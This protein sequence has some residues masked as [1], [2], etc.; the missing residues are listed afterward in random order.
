MSKLTSLERDTQSRDRIVSDINT[1]FFVEAGAGSGKTTMLVSR[2]VAMVEAGIP[3]GKICAITFT[4]AAAGE[5]YERFQKLLIERSNPDYV[6]EDKGYAGQ[7]PEPTDRTRE[8][9]AEALRNIDL[10]FMGTIDSFCSMVLSEHPSEAGI[11]SDS[12]IATDGEAELFYKQ[13]YVK[14]CAGEYDDIVPGLS[15]MADDF[16]GFFR[17]AED[18]FAQ[19]EYVLMNNRNVH[20]NYT[21]PAATDIDRA[22]AADRTD[23]IK[24]L[25]CLTEHP[26]LM[27]PSE[28]NN[29]KAWERIDDT[30]K[31]LKGKWSNNYSGV[32]FAL[33]SLQHLRV[34]PEAMDHYEF[35]LAGVFERGG[36]TGKWFECSRFVEDD[37]LS[38]MQNLQYSA[39]MEFLEACV[40]VLEAAM[41]DKGNMTFF[42]YLYYLRNMLRRDAKGDGK[43][44]RYIYDRHSYFLIDEFQ[45]TNPMQAE[46][47]FY[48]S[49]ENPV[50]QWSACVPRPGS[51]FIVGD[52][53]QSIYRFRSAD[54]TSFLK[55]KGLFTNNGGSVLSLS[56]NFRSTSVLCDYFNRV[57]TGM[58]PEETADQSRFEEIPVPEAKDDEFR[59][60]YT[61]TAYTG[62]LVSAH[63]DET[64]PKQ[65][66]R[67]IE[68]IVDNE[69]YLIRSGDDKT[70]RKLSYSDIMVI[71]YGKKKLGP[72]MALLDE[73][74]IPTKV[75][76][77]VPFGK[78]K[79]LREVYTIYSAVA[80]ADDA[81]SL[82]GALTGRLIGFSK[83]EILAYRSKG[84]NVSLKSTFDVEGCEDRTACLV[85]STIEDLK[86][87]YHSAQRLSPAA[88]FTKIMDDYRVYEIDEAENLE[89][90]YYTLELLRNAEKS[91]KVVSLEG[92]AACI[93]ELLEGVSGEERCLSLND[94]KDAVHMANLHKVKGLEAPVVILAAAT[95]SNNSSDK[96]IVHG[97]DGSEGYLFSL[98]KREGFGSIFETKEFADEQ[99]A[100]KAAGE[101]EKQRLVYVAATR[102]RN[103]L[104]ICDSITS[105]F[106]RETHKSLWKPVMEDGLKDFFEATGDFVPG[107]RVETEC[108][109]SAALYEEAENSCVFNDRAMESATYSL[110]NP[111]RLRLSSKMAEEQEVNLVLAPETVP[112]EKEEKH[113]DL[114]RFPALLGTMTHKL[115]EMLVST[116]NKVDAKVAIDEII[117][118]YRTPMT[119]PYENE[120]AK[121]L[122]DV[123]EKMRSGGYPQANSLPQDMLGTLL[124]ADEVYCEVPFCYSE[125]GEEG[126]ILWNGIMDVVYLSAGKWHIVDYK[127][128]A[129]GSDLDRKYQGQLSAYT[130]AFKATTGEDADAM[131]YHIDI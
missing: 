26:E 76:G 92:G 25:N 113:G 31:A 90:V 121:K 51:L 48:L 74:G 126:R 94:E 63:P 87:L 114:H 16:R 123:A 86:A 6:W 72:I 9:C 82:Y 56:R 19:G 102:A 21:K 55:V 40:P 20:F 88:L 107:P 68:R 98:S 104:I 29:L 14:I 38:K 11:P 89:V 125:D 69:D 60:V 35:E 117:R 111:S 3:I 15:G 78:N 44:I 42:D 12:N 18:V 5:F 34:I 100:E 131:T 105:S 39:S 47:F 84:G 110:E 95:G 99:E 28:Q 93:S 59:G 45:D 1:N 119:E 66:A 49:S 53:K 83:G 124:D 65:I 37:I 129:D 10:C 71:T 120:L 130:K 13:L 36:K 116:G 22:Y 67:I 97:D 112:E 17:N 41:R 127:T 33:K 128:N 43:L 122:S 80:D 54:V 2:M 4:K 118:E 57:F 115:M 24:A 62:G 108:V 46:V 79:A 58:L 8:L 75:E 50:P 23:L 109:D 106:G 101:A 77:E 30:Y 91:G 32:L 81:I 61:Y 103:A 52:P 96:R 85:A 7:L 70:P 73:K 27:Y 64:D